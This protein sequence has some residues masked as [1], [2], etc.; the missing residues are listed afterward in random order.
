[1]PGHTRDQLALKAGVAADYI[2][3]LVDLG[4]LTPGDGQTFSSGDVL[5]ARWVHNFELSGLPLDGIADAIRT[6]DLSLSFLDAS[7]FDRF[8]DVS[9][10]TFEQ[11]SESTGIPLDLLVVVREAFGYAE[12]S[13]QDKVREDELAVITAVEFELSKGFH[14]AAI[15]QL[16]RVYAESMRR[17]AE[18]ETDLYRSEVVEPLL[19]A[20]MSAGEVMDTQA[21]VGS[22]LGP[23]IQEALLAIYH[24]QQEH[25]WVRSAVEW[26]ES[27]L[28]RAGLYNRVLRPPAVSFLDLTGYTRLTEERGDRAAAELAGRLRRM[29]G[30]TSLEHGGEAVK[31]LGDG[32]MSYFPDPAGSV[33]S[34]LEMVE[35]AK[36]RSLPPAR[37]GIHTGP[38]IFQEGDYFGRTVNIASRIADQA[39]PGEVV[40]SQEVVEAMP[41]DGIKFTEI[42]P[43]ELKGV[44]GPLRLYTAHPEG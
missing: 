13:P 43:V 32:V 31:W 37:V 20:E 22:E 25:T 3:L 23:I 12:P 34:A 36:T 21:G 17:I 29:V 4:I 44:E 8:A 14:R 28:E 40:V 1:M 9:D 15:E 35:R 30:Q 18:T 16:L 38:V 41:E 7:A 33:A 5:R 11:V 19:D 42:G 6:G 27:G 26:V 39:P 2:D 24:G 10:N